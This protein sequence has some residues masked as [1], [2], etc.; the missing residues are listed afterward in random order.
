MHPT[1]CTHVYI[2][3][4]HTRSQV[5]LVPWGPTPPPSKPKTCTRCSLHC[6]Q[7]PHQPS[8]TDS[9][10]DCPQPWY[11]KTYG[12][13]RFH[14]VAPAAGAHG[15]S[16]G[17]RA[18]SSACARAQ[19][20]AGRVGQAGHAAM[21]RRA[22]RPRL[23]LLHVHGCTMY[24]SGAC[25]LL[26]THDT[27]SLWVIAPHRHTQSPP[28]PRHTPLKRTLLP[29]SY[30]TPGFASA[31]CMHTDRERALLMEHWR[32]EA[33]AG[34]RQGAQQ[35]RTARLRE[36]VTPAWHFLCDHCICGQST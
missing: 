7:T 22:R 14:T 21:A 19:C 34:T 23:Q 35:E 1:Q 26:C 24:Q 13:C 15:S 32:Q 4:A 8:P 33:G 3:N 17:R 2:H 12:V 27:M 29:D 31:H 9:A 6:T 36:G 5:D 11:A 20:L 10:P 30:A 28:T 16:T 25:V 18:A